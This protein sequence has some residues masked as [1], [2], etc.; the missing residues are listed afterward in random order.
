MTFD[1]DSDAEITQAWCEGLRPEPLLT[2][3]A[4]ADQYRMLSPKAAA[5][6]GRWR[7]AR[8]PYLRAIMDCLSPHSP[9]ERVVFMKGA[10]IGGSECGNCWIGYVIH[11]APGPMMAVVPTV[12]LAKRTSKQRIE[13]LILD[14][15]V[16][17]E[18]VAPSRSRDA[19]NTLLT[20][21]FRGGVLVITGANSAVGLRSMP[22]RYLF[23]D[24]VDGYPPDVDGEGDA[25][26]L[27]EA[28]TRTFV[29]RKIFIVSTP[30]ITGHSRIEAEYRDSDQRQYHLPCPFCHALAPLTWA[31]MHWDEAVQRAWISCPHCGAVIDEHHKHSMLANGQW[32]AQ[33]PFTGA[34]GFHLSEL[35]SP[36]RRWIAL[37]RQFL[38]A[39]AVPERLKVFVN[40]TLGE[41]WNDPDAAK[42]TD[43]DAIR[44]RREPYT[45]LPDSAVVVLLLVDVQDD[46]L[47]LE[48]KAF[49]AG[50]ESWGIEYT[51][52]VGDPGGAELWQRLDQQ[53]GRQFRRLDGAVLTVQAAGIDS[54]GHYTSHVYAW[55][56]RHRGRA[57]ALKGIGGEGRPLIKMGEKVRGQYIRLWMVGVDAGKDLL[58][59]S[60]LRITA[61]GEGYLHFPATYP[62][63]YFDELC[64][65]RV[66]TAYRKGR[67]TRAWVLQGHR[68]NE[69]LDLNV[70]ALALIALI[71]P[72][73][74][75]LGEYLKQ[76]IAPETEK[77]KMLTPTG[78]KPRRKS[79][80]WG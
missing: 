46:R 73:Y 79:E 36:W 57:F 28:R 72:A 60:R 54:G 78:A 20:K 5:E 12:E 62:D 6:P 47:Q 16:L 64:A 37:V 30:T 71:K 52:L 53:M 40:T 42:G 19:H 29:R 11:H 48:F 21:E 77:P 63:T 43:A 69:A 70:Y 18:R 8:T 13:P 17:R 23:L 65:E 10:Q 44:V 68:R 75:S 15:P 34:A 67:P 55:A 2:V 61:P 39:K 26:A 45:Q 35:Y 80:F 4:W 33:A 66:I 50:E 32:I 9:V 56:R 51:T 27:A 76:T 49:G 38:K 14:T 59:H 24:E 58:H 25:L 74:Q 31:H 41:T 1:L 7:T 22:V 3:S